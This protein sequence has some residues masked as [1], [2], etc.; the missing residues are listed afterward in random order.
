MGTSLIR[1]WSQFDIEEIKKHMM[2]AGELSASCEKC[3]HFGINFAL[4][5]EC[6][7]CRTPF[8]YICLRHKDNKSDEL[9]ALGRLKDKRPDL[10][11]I[12][13]DDIKRAAGKS[14]AHQLFERNS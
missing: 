10:V 2:V 12:E 11:I 8:H 1:V 14:K 5:R 4:A 9:S 6:P 13:Y 7:N 3:Q